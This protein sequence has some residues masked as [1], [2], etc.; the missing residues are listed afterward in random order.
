MIFINGECSV[1]KVEMAT[2]QL[3]AAIHAYEQGREIEAI[4]L[5]GA[6]EE[7]FG[8]MCSRDCLQN[9][10]EKVIRLPAIQNLS[11]TDK[12]KINFLNDVRNN[13]KHANDSD[14]DTFIVSEYDAFVIIARALA[15]ASILGVKDTNTMLRF[16]SGDFI[17]DL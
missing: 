6:S 10:L 8:S 1:S 15:N 5:A 12:E 2:I 7:I 9:A 17:K 14:E 13:L 3:D 11:T 4:T 16:R